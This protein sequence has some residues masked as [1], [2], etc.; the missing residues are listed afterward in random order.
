M[1]ERVPPKKIC[2]DMLLSAGT[3]QA[4]ICHDG[5]EFS[6]TVRSSTLLKNVLYVRA[7]GEKKYT[8]KIQVTP[9]PAP[10]H[11]QR[12]HRQAEGYSNQGTSRTH[13]FWRGNHTPIFD[14]ETPKA[15]SVITAADC[16]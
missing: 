4:R 8:P 6:T 5:L 7:S 3:R 13:Q 15:H 1:A 11:Q 16:M 10:W 2:L 9:L 12:Q 14:V